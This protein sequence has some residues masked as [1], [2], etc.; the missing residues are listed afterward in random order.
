M[1][2]PVASARYEDY[3]GMDGV[4]VG[5]NFEN[6]DIRQSL[7]DSQTEMAK[8]SAKFENKEQGFKNYTKRIMYT[9]GFVEEYFEDQRCAR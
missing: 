6:R 9:N 2:I 5:S 8:M 1:G 7:I 3:T 4:T